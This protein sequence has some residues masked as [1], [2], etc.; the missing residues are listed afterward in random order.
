MSQIGVSHLIEVASKDPAVQ[1]E[2][3]FTEPHGQ[4][5]TVECAPKSRYRLQWQLADDM[6]L[7]RPQNVDNTRVSRCGRKGNTGSEIIGKQ[8]VLLTCHGPTMS[9][10]VDL[11][12]SFSASRLRIFWYCKKAIKARPSPTGIGRHLIGVS[13]HALLTR[14]KREQRA[15]AIL[16]S[17]S[18]TQAYFHPFRKN[19]FLC[20]WMLTTIWLLARV[21]LLAK[22]A[23]G[24]VEV[25]AEEVGRCALG[26]ARA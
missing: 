16:V 7:F 13:L 23:S 3:W 21:R 5:D 19:A 1:F 12:L 10:C 8:E 11:S 4:R 15:C 20:P 18:N 2:S 6:D 25:P 17:F 26:R 24:S 14:S 22:G 9:A